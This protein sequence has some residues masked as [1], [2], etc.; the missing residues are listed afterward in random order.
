MAGKTSILH[1]QTN[2]QDKLASITCMWD[3]SQCIQ[4]ENKT[5]WFLESRAFTTELWNQHTKKKQQGCPTTF[6]FKNDSS[7]SLRTGS[8]LPEQELLPLASAAEAI[9]NRE[10]PAVVSKRICPQAPNSRFVS[11]WQVGPM[12]KSSSRSLAKERIMLTKPKPIITDTTKRLMSSPKCRSVEVIN[13][14]ARPGSNHREV[15]CINYK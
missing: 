4:L 9:K 7:H 10:T 15:N 8:E 5:K 6:R 11:L 13:N 12:N 1:Q 3:T 14:P 2:Q